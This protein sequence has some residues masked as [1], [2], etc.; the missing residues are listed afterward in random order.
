[1]KTVML[2][3]A[4]ASWTLFFGLLLIMA[5]NGLQMV[6]LG[7]RSSDAGF[8]NV[9]TGVMMAGYYFGLFLG[10][11]S[12]PKIL[13][14]VG[15]VRVFGAM[16]AIASAAVLAHVAIVD[17]FVW[18]VMRVMT[19]F[20][21]AGMYIVCESWLNDQSTNETRGQMLSLYMIVSMGGLALGQL[22]IS[23]GSETGIG[24]FLLA[25][26][27]VSIAVVPI[28]ITVG[29]APEFSTP[30][31][32]SLRRIFQISPLAVIGLAI[33]GMAISMVFGM[34]AVYG[35]SIG[36][37]S[38][39]IGYFMT[40]PVIGAMLL[41]YPVG[42]LSDRFDRRKVI[43]GVSS[44]A[45][46][47]LLI[48]WQFGLDQFSLLLLC[49]LLFGGFLFPMYS[50]CIAHAND[51]LAPSQMVAVASGLVMV[52]GAGAVAGS[53]LAAVCIEF[54][55]VNS[56]FPLMATAQVATTIVVIIRMT[57]RASVPTEAQGPFVA[58]PEAA[59]AIAATLNPESEWVLS[60]EEVAEAED[61]FK[62]NPYVN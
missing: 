17:P 37:S 15:H 31:P 12:V 30:E 1:M 59:G 39:Q 5:G 4:A 16:A 14:N 9:A 13:N 60:D 10:S 54:L 35:K 6:L 21:F 34:G 55:G 33:N 38:T 18:T 42:R 58:I 36:M 44:T 27:L 32:I 28:L 61:P 56:F 40:A 45:A 24:L 26:V 53:P 11:I 29:K 57:R 43:L 47:I 22:M 2:R 48:A 51:F 52:S 49:M 25:S 7:I 20:S 8:S 23:L 19:G 50:L 46:I 3:S 41:Q 62:D